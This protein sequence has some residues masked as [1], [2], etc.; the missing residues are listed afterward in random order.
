MK[1]SGPV[2]HSQSTLTLTL[3]EYH[4]C[5]A[6]A[7]LFCDLTGYFSYLFPPFTAQQAKNNARFTIT[8]EAPTGVERR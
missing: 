3:V 2:V 5:K 8:T 4:I 1:K 6:I 7:R